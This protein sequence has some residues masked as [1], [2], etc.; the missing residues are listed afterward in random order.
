M[1][2]GRTLLDKKSTKGL[3]VFFWFAAV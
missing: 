3:A 2:K 1:V